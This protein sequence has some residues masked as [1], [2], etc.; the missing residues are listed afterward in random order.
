MIDLYVEISSIDNAVDSLNN[1]P[2]I[3]NKTKNIIPSIINLTHQ[4]HDERRKYRGGK[5]KK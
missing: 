1:L 3:S 2:E 4:I 5:R